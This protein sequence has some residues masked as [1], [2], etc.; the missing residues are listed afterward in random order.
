[1]TKDQQLHHLISALQ[2]QDS[3]LPA[4]VSARLEALADK[5]DHVSVVLFSVVKYAVFALRKTL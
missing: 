5:G 1:V 2:A 4:Q 3:V